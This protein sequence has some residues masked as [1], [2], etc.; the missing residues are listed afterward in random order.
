MGET[1]TFD[2]WLSYLETLHPSTIELG[3]SRILPIALALNL[4]HFEAKVV[5]VGGTNGKGSVVKTLEQVSLRAGYKVASYTSPHLLHFSERLQINNQSLSSQEWVAAFIKIEQARGATALTF[6]EFTTL[7]ALLLCKQHKLDIIILEVGLGGRKDAVNCVESDLAIVTNVDIDHVD[8]L[9]GTRE[10]IGYEKAGIFRAGKVALCGDPSP[11]LSLLQAAKESEV[12]LYMF[13]KQYTA[14]AGGTDWDFCITGQRKIKLP[15]PNLEL[16]NVATGLMAL[17]LI[18]LS[19]TDLVIASAMQTLKLPGRY[20]VL[21]HAPKIILDVAHNPQAATLLAQKLSR[22]FPR[23][24]CHAV[25]GMRQDKDY[26]K[27]ISPLLELIDSWYTVTI[28][29]PFALEAI[30]LTQHLSKCGAC[31]YTANS[32]EQALDALLP[33]CQADDIVVIFGSFYT[34]AAAKQVRALPHR[35]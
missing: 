26:V 8:W 28:N 34:V 20:E 31:C 18:G 13:G 19:A 3:L 16:Q 32:M 14:V 12:E 21:Q 23:G 25:I 15:Q 10:A 9:G 4:T 2:E 35:N 5:T 7:A 22:E 33:H 29:S 30:K 17:E 11:P 27:V 6:F 24:R 1:A